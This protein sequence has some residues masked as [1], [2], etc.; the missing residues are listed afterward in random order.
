[1]SS[2]QLADKGRRSTTNGTRQ[3]HLCDFDG[4]LAHGDSLRRFLWFALPASRL[5]WGSMVVAF[6]FFTLLF[7]GK[8]SNEAGKAALLSTFFRGRTTVAM[9]ALGAGFYSKKIPGLL[10]TDLL[11]KL[12]MAV[13]NGETVVIVSASLDLWLRPFCKLEGFDLLCTELKFMD[14]KFTGRLA[15]PNCN[16]PEKAKRILAAYNLAFFDK[17]TA[18]G[19]STGDHA[20]FELADEVFKF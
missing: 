16:G 1:M 12:R 14:G 17:I 4:T 20:M 2:Q 9:K 7:S 15:T 19:N 6:K 8:W 10:R 11:E 3:L 13:K 18:Y 5:V